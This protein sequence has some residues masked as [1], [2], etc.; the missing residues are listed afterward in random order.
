MSVR[1]I[2]HSSSQPQDQVSCQTVPQLSHSYWLRNAGWQ[3][4]T[5]AWWVQ[6]GFFIIAV[7]RVDQGANCELLV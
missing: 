3:R 5:S 4:R 6:F 7:V 1:Q 2:G